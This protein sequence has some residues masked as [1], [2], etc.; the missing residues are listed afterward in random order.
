VTR[1]ILDAEVQVD[2]DA[3]VDGTDDI[4]VLSRAG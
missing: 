3:V 1:A 4:C 2:E